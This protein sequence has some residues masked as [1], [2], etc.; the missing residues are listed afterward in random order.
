[1]AAPVP[2]SS[3]PVVIY[4]S[5]A[6]MSDRLKQALDTPSKCVIDL[7][8]IEDDEARAVH[9]D[10]KGGCIY[11][12]QCWQDAI[13]SHAKWATQCMACKRNI[14]T[15]ALF[16]TEERA[17][18]IAQIDAQRRSLWKDV[19]VTAVHLTIGLSSGAVSMCCSAVAGYHMTGSLSET[20][21]EEG[22][23]E[24]Q[25]IAVMALFLGGLSVY[26][27]YSC[28]GPHR[29]LFS[30]LEDLLDTWI[31]LRELGRERAQLVAQR[32]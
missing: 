19:F 3:L 15:S 9:D 4:S 5:R 20:M 2:V 10:A 23:I 17:Q 7:D 11:H 29:S 32:A 16:T 12:P 26:V 21:S 8:I 28:L 27:T 18:R 14:D 24:H 31:E 6:A 13:H 1:M 30:Q 25:T 22:Q